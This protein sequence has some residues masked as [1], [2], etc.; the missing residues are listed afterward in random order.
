MAARGKF[1]TF[2]GLDGAGKSTHIPF[3]AELIRQRG[4]TVV[5]TR[6]PGG[7]PLGEELRRILLATPMHLETETLL[8]F[9]ARREHV[10]NLIEPALARG[11]WVLCDRFTDATFAY[12][13]GGRALG[14]EKVAT[15]AHWV[16]A[17]T[18]PDLTLLFD[19]PLETAQARI[20]ANRE[21]KDRFEAEAVTFHARVREAYLARAHAEPTRMR[22]IDGSRTIANI[23]KLLQQMIATI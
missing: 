6:E 22:I 1:I 11:N 23:E 13:G 14:V 15:L 8:M 20:A 4:E 9:A 3:L 2:E 21:G 18:N 5:V 19:V 7:T 12:Q 16:H 17:R 10:A